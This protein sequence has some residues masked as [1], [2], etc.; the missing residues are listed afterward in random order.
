MGH[1]I[2]KD[3]LKPDPD[4]VAAIKNMPKPMSTCTY[5]PCLLTLLGF[6]N[7]LS[8]FLPKLSGVFA[9]S[10]ELTSDQAEFTWA[11]EHDEAFTTL[12]QLVIQHPVLKFYNVE[13]R[14]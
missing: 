6:V 12:Q 10:R 13:D 5:T 3:G 7:Y 14:C 1:V 8:K 2:S 4:K 9:P 11:K